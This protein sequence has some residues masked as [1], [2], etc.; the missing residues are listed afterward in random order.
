MSSTPEPTSPRSG[1][2][3]SRLEAPLEPVG[4]GRVV[5]VHARDVATASLVE[6]AI[7]RCGETEL[8]L[9]PEHAHSRIRE[10]VE[11]AP[12]SVGGAVVD[13]DELEIGDGLAQD[14]EER[15]PNERLAVVHGDEDGDERRGRHRVS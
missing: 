4:E 9:V 6:S 7:Q 12:R 5:G 2:E 3:S 10:S 11:R 1:R 8:R 15:R 13:D 14:A